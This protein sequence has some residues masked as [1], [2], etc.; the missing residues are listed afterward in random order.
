MLFFFC[1]KKAHADTNKDDYIY[2]YMWYSPATPPP[3][4]MVTLPSVDRDSSTAP[5]GWGGG[6]FFRVAIVTKVKTKRRF[7]EISIET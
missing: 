2:I 5:C 1:K 3:P 6:I 4:V 7:V